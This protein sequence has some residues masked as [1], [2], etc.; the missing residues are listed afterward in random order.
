MS[1]V[2]QKLGTLNLWSERVGS[3]DDFDINFA[4]LVASQIAVAV[5]A[6]FHREQPSRERDRSQ[7]LL[8]VNNTLVSNLSLREL[9]SAISGAL[10]TI[11]P[12]EAAVLTLYD[13]SRKRNY[14]L[15]LWIFLMVRDCVERMRLFP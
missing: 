12:H 6:E 2:H 1:T 7:L 8:Q 9:V 4:Q 15:R 11:M 3:Y 5:E 14:A 10:S 13:E